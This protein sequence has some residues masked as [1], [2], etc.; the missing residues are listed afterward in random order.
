MN[1]FMNDVEII[2]DDILHH[3]I[4]GGYNTIIKKSIYPYLIFKKN[5]EWLYQ[6][7]KSGYVNKLGN[8][9][10]DVIE[11]SEKVKNFYREQKLTRILNEF[12]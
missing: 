6:Y 3:L 2:T 11:K 7:T 1:D 5:D 12:Q 4:I 9:L 10:I 8:Q